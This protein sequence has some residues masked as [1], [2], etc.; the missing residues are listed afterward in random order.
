MSIF[1]DDLICRFLGWL[2]I[3][4][5]CSNATINQRLFTIRAFSRYAQQE[6]PQYFLQ[7]GRIL[8]MR[9]RHTTKP[10]VGYVDE[11]S[12]KKIFQNPDTTSKN[13]RRD[14]VLLCLLYDTGARVSE[15][16]DL[17]V[18]DVRLDT[19][20][21]IRLF[22][23]GR[24]SR[25]VPILPKTSAMLKNYMQENLMLDAG[26]NNYPLFA[27]RLGQRLTRAGVA[28]ILQK[29]VMDLKTVDGLPISPH[30][31][32]HT[33]AMH[34]LQ[35]GVSIVYIKDLLGHVDLKT[36]EVYARADLE[37]KRKALEKGDSVSPAVAPVWKT[38]SNLLTWLEELANPKQ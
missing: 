15:I 29:Y 26:K 8:H 30:V 13:G 9:K 23:K 25:D 34:L 21:K 7:F 38:D 3:E 22:G 16:T 1:S 27:N 33:K 14:L 19:P 4:R 2:E 6:M 36:T 20:A 10:Q 18:R 32:R 35:S 28:Y 31:I 12:I 17:S 37:M 24:K 11:D 5:G